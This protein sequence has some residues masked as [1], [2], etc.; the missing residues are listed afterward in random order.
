MATFD[1]GTAECAVFTFKEG[2]LS[3]IA[4]DLE[5]RVARFTIAV[6]DDL[7]IDARFDA[8]SLTVLHAL[9]DGR[10][11][12]ALSPADRRSIER[13]I[14]DDVLEAR[15]HPEI[16]FR[17]STVKAADGAALDGA[18]ELHGVRRPLRLSA[19]TEGGRRVVETVVHQPD[20]GIRPYRA[21]LGT[22]RLR[23]DVRVRVSIP[24]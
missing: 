15:R 1:A 18:L 5:L 4:H 21:F 2:M 13:T 9:R 23:A 6:G 10:P 7:T 8:A 11:S 16:R 22:L 24:A 20:F 3:A 14:L 17:A 19:R 12:D